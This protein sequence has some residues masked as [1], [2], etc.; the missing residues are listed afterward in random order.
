MFPRI[1]IPINTSAAFVKDLVTQPD[2]M[3]GIM[4]SPNIFQKHSSTVVNNVLK[5]VEAIKLWQNIDNRST[6]N[7]ERHLT[8]TTVTGLIQDPS[9]LLQYVSKD[10]HSN[11]HFCNIC[12][13]FSHQWKASVRNH[14]ESKHFPDIFTYSCQQC[15]ETFRSNQALA[16]HRSRKHWQ[17]YI[18]PIKL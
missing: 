6:E 17:F 10:L 11:K 14:V 18:K 5:L 12:N 4:W 1:H 16:K 9:E 8:I 7:I 3:F 2:L 15:S 13:G